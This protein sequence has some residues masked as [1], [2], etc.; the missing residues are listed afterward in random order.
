MQ[1]VILDVII[2]Q[3]IHHVSSV[4][5]D[6]FIRGHCAK[7]DFCKSLGRKHPETNAAD[8]PV[9]FDES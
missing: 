4:S 6:L 5:F 9:V 3:V 1:N 7:D 8:G 2:F